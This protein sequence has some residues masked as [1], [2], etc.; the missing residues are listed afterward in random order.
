MCLGV[1]ILLDRS[2]PAAAAL[3]G[4]AV[5]VGLIVRLPQIRITGLFAG[6]V[7]LTSALVDLPGRIHLGRF[8]A[9]AA[10]TILYAA[11]AVIVIA[12]Y[13]R[14]NSDR[15]AARPLWAFAFLL[16]LGGISVLWAAPSVSAVQNLLVLFIFLACI[17]CGMAIARRGEAV[18]EFASMSFGL[19]SAVALAL[20]AASLARGGI[21]SGSVVGTRSFALFGLVAISWG[22]TGWRYKGKYA[23]ALTLMSGLLIMLSLS[24]IAFAA[25]L[26]IVSLAWLNPKS[27]IAW[28]RFFAVVGLMIA[29][30][31]EASMHIRPLHDRIY[32]GDLRSFAGGVSINVTGRADL[33]STTWHS[34]LTSPWI[35]H[36][37]GTA[38]VL[39]T[40]NYSAAIGHPH[41]DYLRLLHDY[42]ALGTALWAV[43]YGW[44]LLRTWRAWQARRRRGRAFDD[45][46]APGQMTEPRIHAAAFLSLL[47]V[48]LAMITDNVIIYMFVM[49]PVGVL[50]G[51]SLGLSAREE[52]E[53][54]RSYWLR[55]PRSI[56]DDRL[57]AR[58]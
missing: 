49:G 39:I 21:G 12:T 33:W 46:T 35:G 48:A 28:M 44:L 13:G 29:I 16:S 10:L 9:N 34:F 42:G 14:S 25:A 11:F 40:K 3:G 32:T 6:A 23:R 55:R 43:G 31:F 50:A 57:A 56:R 26:V 18:H 47:G 27:G 17:L 36:G 22:V 19:S 37:V 54:R 1:G 41:N 5:F 51:L 24:R 53:L 15:P 52:H 45:H 2:P 38:D 8:T 30:A 58:D 7:M 4:L 20:Y